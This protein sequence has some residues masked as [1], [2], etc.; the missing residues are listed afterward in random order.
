MTNSSQ[1]KGIQALNWKT[2][3]NGWVGPGLG[4]ELTRVSK[5]VDTGWKHDAATPILR[6]IFF[7]QCSFSFALRNLRGVHFREFSHPH[8]QLSHMHGPVSTPTRR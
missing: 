7:A 3:K 1:I 4:G 8:P 5:H 2:K 6:S